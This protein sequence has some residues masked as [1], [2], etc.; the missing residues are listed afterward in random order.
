MSA[1]DPFQSLSDAYDLAIGVGAPLF[2]DNGIQIGMYWFQKNK[3][4]TTYAKQ[5]LHPDEFEFF[6][7]S[8]V[9]MILDVEPERI[10]PAI[11]YESLQQQHA[12]NA[13]GLGASVYLCSA[14]KPMSGVQKAMIH[15][16]KIAKIYNMPI[17]FVNS[18][19]HCD[20]F[21]SAG[22]SSV[23]SSEGTL[24]AQL[25]DVSEG[26]LLFDTKD[27]SVEATKPMRQR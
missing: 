25:D 17:T 6:V 22:M 16:P 4:M 24:L 13:F 18:V 3:R 12:E 20:N 19:G 2:S 7:P 5:I 1:F 26:M 11:C 8:A 9:Q 23:F 10:A 27:N 14:A 21:L 15:Y